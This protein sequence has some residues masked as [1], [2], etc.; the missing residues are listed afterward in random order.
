MEADSGQDISKISIQIRSADGNRVNLEESATNVLKSNS[1]DYISTHHDK[2]RS[3]ARDH[4]TGTFS[5]YQPE[6]RGAP[7]SE[8]VKVHGRGVAGRVMNLNSSVMSSTL[9]AFNPSKNTKELTLSAGRTPE[10]A[11]RTAGANDYP[12]LPTVP[13]VPEPG[14]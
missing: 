12:V 2:E 7:G 3:P 8:F 10:E 13:R 1:G 11:G 4:V 9:D 6:K 5:S 14:A